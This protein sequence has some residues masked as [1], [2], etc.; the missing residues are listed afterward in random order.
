M[1]IFFSIKVFII[2]PVLIQ[3]INSLYFIDSQAYNHVIQVKVNQN[4]I[5]CFKQI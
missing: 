4:I 2:I 3:V 1:I 5:K